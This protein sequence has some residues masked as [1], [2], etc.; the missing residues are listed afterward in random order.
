MTGKE[1]IKAVF[2]RKSTERPP[3]VPFAGVHAGKLIGVKA[4]RILQDGELLVEAL[5][6]V[7]TLYQVDGQPVLFDLQIE[8]EVL[9]C[10]L[11]WAQDAPPSVA[12]HPLADTAGLPTHIPQRHEGRIPVVLKAM[13]T[14]KKD[15]GNHTALY[16]LVTGPFTLAAHLRGTEI[17]MDMIDQP[18]YIHGLLSYTTEVAKAMSE[19][20]VEAGMDVIAIV[21]PMVSQ[22][23]PDHFKEFMHSP[24]STLF[25]CIQR[26]GAFSSFFVCGNA[27]ANIEPMCLTHPD[28]ISVDENVHLPHAKEI[29]DRYGIVIGGNLPLT[30]VM[31]LGTQED[32]MKAVLDL[33]DS[34][35]PGSWIVS[36]GCDMP[37]DTPIENCV[38]VA[39]AVRHPEK[40]RE[41]VAHYTAK[42]IPF[43]GTLPDYAHLSKPLVEVFTLDSATC[44]ACG[45]MVEAAKEAVKRFQ[46]QVD[47]VEYKY[48]VRENVAR[49]RVMG[50]KQLPSLYINGELAYS[51]LIPA[52]EELVEKIQTKLKG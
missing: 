47:L 40:A 21:D 34:L 24:F 43:E 37:Y 12:S 6:R 8:A 25:S 16:G 38:A 32:N 14:M 22:I 50:V 48:T 39:Q 23:S 30:T 33:M 52:V 4:D 10:E 31:L 51:S 27:T 41:M 3:W 49:C 44:A 36:P 1:L 46:G 15:V 7:N 17:F 20:Y 2:A 28:C 11:H 9:G 5:K 45:Y 26:L 35:T 18:S 19:Y 29:T 42:D 13:R